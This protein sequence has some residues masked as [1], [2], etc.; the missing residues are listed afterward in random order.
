MTTTLCPLYRDMP[1]L[2][3]A[4]SLSGLPSRLRENIFHCRDINTDWI[5]NS[6]KKLPPAL[7]GSNI[8]AANI[9]I[10][11]GRQYDKVLDRPSPIISS[12][13]KKIQVWDHF[14]S[15]YSNPIFQLYSRLSFVSSLSQLQAH[16][17]WRRKSHFGSYHSW[18]YFRIQSVWLWHGKSDSLSQTRG[19][20]QWRRWFQG[21]VVI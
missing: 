18:Q 10:Q 19:S 17:N 9:Y 7:H 12:M 5:S 13:H 4:L 6:R 11:P 14:W 1:G 16:I 3:S 20:Y 21:I 15:H 8:F 2:Q